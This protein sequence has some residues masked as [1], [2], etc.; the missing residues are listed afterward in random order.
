MADLKGLSERYSSLSPG[1]VGL[2]RGGKRILVITHLD[3]DGLCSGSVVFS[4]LMRKGA[5]A[6]LRSIPDL[7]SKT[8][9]KLG[10]EGYD[11]YIFTDLA[12]TLVSEL[13]SVFD[14]HFLVIDHHQMTP[15]DLAKPS[16]V[17]AWQ[18]SFDGGREACS[19]SM[20]YA[21]AVALDPGNTDLSPLALVGALA[22]RQDPGEGRSV[23]G[24]NRWAL[25][26][27]VS[28]G[29]VE[30]SKDL[31]FSGRETRPVHEAVALTTTPYLPGLSGS[32]DAVLKELHEAGIQ[33]KDG[34]NWRTISSL[35]PQ[36][37]G[38]LTEVIAGRLAATEGATEAMASLVG[39]VYTL[40]AEDEFTPLR[41]AR[42]FGT[43]LN[44]CGRMA[45][46]GTGIGVCLGDRG[47]ALRGALAVLAEYRSGIGKALELLS[48]QPG[49]IVPHGSLLIVDGIGAI[50]EK[51][52]GPVMSILT[53]S[54][55]NK[56]KVVVGMSSS[57]DSEIKVSSRVGD[58]HAGQV[59]L[60][61]LMRS[62]AEKVGGVGGG[63]EMAAGAKIP[64]SAADAFTK[65]VVEQVAG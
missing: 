62:S 44:A 54:P 51:L 22:D 49:R 4:A 37:K 13:E 38:K 45:A 12:S 33:L 48:S 52:L 29:L 56:D 11:Y 23:T 28:A 42:E 58:A 24:L 61:L 63:H 16:V 3:A 21:F 20:A 57:G 60:G 1:L 17:N 59:N 5:N 36:E 14:G 47:D 2:A 34:S 50:D 15:E 39:E 35:S 27:A 43:L 65:A 32:R 30:V 18:Y 7:D 8:I 41:D 53:S 46:T 31:L 19:S 25:E 10:A 26:D 64:A 55:A 6:A 9:A 40:K